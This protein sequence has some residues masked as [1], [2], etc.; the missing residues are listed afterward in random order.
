LPLGPPASKQIGVTEVTPMILRT[1]DLQNL[2][3]LSLPAFRT[4]LDIE[5]DRLAFLKAAEAI[6]LD[7]G[8]VDE[9]VLT[10]LA[11]DKTKTLGVV[12]PLNCSLFHFLCC[13]FLC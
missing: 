2:N 4:L 1:P 13:S 10:I 5:L 3:V 11:A 8:V 6:R 12:E 7:G 9:N